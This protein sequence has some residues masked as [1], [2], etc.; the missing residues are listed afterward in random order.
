MGYLCCVI[1]A[2]DME[3]FRKLR[4]EVESISGFTEHEEDAP[5]HVIELGIYR[6]TG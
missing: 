3:E 2:I 5:D 4:Y 6:V 1:T